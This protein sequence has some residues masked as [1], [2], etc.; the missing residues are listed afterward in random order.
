VVTAITSDT[1]LNVGYKIGN[2]TSQTINKIPAIAKIDNYLGAGK[3]FIDG[4]GRI[5]VGAPAGA[6]GNS[7]SLQL[8]SGGLSGLYSYSANDIDPDYSNVFTIERARG[9][10][11]A[12]T[13]MQND[14]TIFTIF[15][16]GYDGTTLRDTAS[17][18]MAADGAVSTGVV[19]TRITFSTGVTNTPIERMRITSSGN[20]GIGTTSPQY[21][22]HVGSA[23]VASGTVARFQN[24]NGTCDINPTDASL[25]CSSDLRL[26]QNINSMASSSAEML[27]NVLALN[28]VYFNWNSEASGTPEHPGFIAQQVEQLFPDL[29]S[30]DS[31]GLK[32]LSYSNFAPYLVSALQ[33]QEKQILTLQGSLTGNAT[34]S[35]LAVYSPSNFSGDSVG[36]AKILAAQTSV[37]VNFK[38]AYQYQ[39]IVTITPIGKFV[40]GYVTDVDATGFTIA[41]DS[42]GQPITGLTTDSMFSWHSFASPEAQLTVSDGTTQDIVLVVPE[43]V[44]PVAVVPVEPDP[45]SPKPSDNATTTVV[46]DAPTTTPEVLDASV[47]V[48]E[49][50]PVLNPSPVVSDTPAPESIQEPSDPVPMP[51]ETST[52]P[53]Q[54]AP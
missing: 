18:K 23:S 8:I 25:E 26:K 17:I 46:S 41:I 7:I 37:R 51:P 3:V 1:S 44:A 52:E 15:G 22:L 10:V 6:T 50:A 35:N 13:A 36:E 49:V 24:I 12:P 43:P 2:G 54:A 40:P 33:A 42:Y 9:T 32:S 28:P 31:N 16:G 19:P 29:V 53:V 5:G 30:T 4:S 38:Q 11:L 34:T 47:P 14:D 20:V 39:P 45:A 21:L 27:Q 48:T